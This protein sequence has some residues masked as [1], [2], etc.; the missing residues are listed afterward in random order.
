MRRAADIR[1]QTPDTVS[2]SGRPA[3]TQRELRETFVRPLFL[4][5]LDHLPLRLSLA[6]RSV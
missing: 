4:D 1:D 3:A 2:N 6:G 5:I